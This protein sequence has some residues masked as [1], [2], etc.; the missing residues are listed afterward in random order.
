MGDLN[1]TP[2][3]ASI[4]DVLEAG[5]R[6]EKGPWTDLMADHPNAEGSY[7]HQGHW[8]F[9]DHF[10]IP[11]RMTRDESKCAF[12]AE[13]PKVHRFPWLLRERRGEGKEERVP[14]RTFGGPTYIG[15]ISDHLP[16]SVVLREE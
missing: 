15:G 1:D 7:F 11:T 5:G 14:H 9:L 6:K 16:V 13:L 12:K 3:N 2:S 8:S 4:R 10:I